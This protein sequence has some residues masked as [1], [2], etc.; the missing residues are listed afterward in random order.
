MKRKGKTADKEY[1]QDYEDEDWNW[2]DPGVQEEEAEEAA[3][4]VHEGAYT[5]KHNEEL[6]DGFQGKNEDTQEAMGTLAEAFKG[7]QGRKNG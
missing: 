6:F 2:E 3:G 5:N 1:S 7:D 4:T